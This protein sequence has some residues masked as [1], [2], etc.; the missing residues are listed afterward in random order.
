MHD[1][2]FHLDTTGQ[3]PHFGLKRGIINTHNEESY[4]RACKYRSK[5]LL[6]SF[7]LHPWY[8]YESVQNYMQFY[9]ACDVIGEIGMDCVWTQRSLEEQR[10][11]FIKQ[12]QIAQ[13]LFKPVIL[14]T[15]GC[16]A[17]IADYISHYPNTYLIHWYSSMNDIEK[18]INLDCYFSIGP[19]VV[20]DKAVQQ[21]A[22]K[23]PLDRI[24]IESDGLEAI[25]W[26][27][28]DEIDYQQAM[29][30]SI[31]KISQLKN[32]ST[33]QL[34]KQLTINYQNFIQKTAIR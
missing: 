8:Q 12:L 27:Y 5:T 3:L 2:H 18:F 7:G 26:A 29:Q 13:Q 25:H 15:K 17:E 9:Q 28:G 30:N 1:A 14:H 22:I 10:T 21:C 11:L 20:H 16:E 19:S 31:N 4:L 6:V 24:L 32:I 23:V 34:E 33:H